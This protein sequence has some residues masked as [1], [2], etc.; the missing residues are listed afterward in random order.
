[1]RE[2]NK[3]AL[4]ADREKLVKQCGEFAATVRHPK[5]DIPA[6]FPAEFKSVYRTR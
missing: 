1:M 5:S 4:L 3:K 2:E 6:L